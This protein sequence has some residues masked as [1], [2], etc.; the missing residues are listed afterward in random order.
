MA[1]TLREFNRIVSVVEG[2]YHEAALKWG[3]TDSEMHILYVLCFHETG[4]LQSVF[5]KETGMVKSTV[6]S[7]IGKMEREGIVF[8]TPADGRNTRVSLT[9]KGERLVQNTVYKIVQAENAIYAGW[10]EGERE[11]FLHLN[12]DYARRLGD[13][14]AAL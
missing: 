10:S 13:M 2:I 6:N 3:M 14:V 5:Y 12:R 11:L 1:S 7:A 8:L 9:A 4:C